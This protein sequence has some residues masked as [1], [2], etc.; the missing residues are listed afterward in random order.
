MTACVFEHRKGR[1]NIRTRAR[2]RRGHPQGNLHLDL[3]PVSEE[4]QLGGIPDEL[5]GD[6]V[7]CSNIEHDRICALLYMVNGR[8]E[9]LMRV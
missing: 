4:A 8:V 3:L 9:L 7:A 5:L 6:E 1:S 2:T